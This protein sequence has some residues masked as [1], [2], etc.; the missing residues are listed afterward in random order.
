MLNVSVNI[1][2]PLQTLANHTETIHKFYVLVIPLNTK[3]HF[4]VYLVL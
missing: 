2:E 3:L 1:H 4:Y